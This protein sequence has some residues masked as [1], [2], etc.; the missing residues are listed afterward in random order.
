MSKKLINC[1]IITFDK[2][3]QGSKLLFTITK[4][5]ISIKLSIFVIK[6][7]CYYTRYISSW[8]QLHLLF[9]HLILSCKYF[10]KCIQQWLLVIEQVTS[11]L[12]QHLTKFTIIIHAYKCYS[13][14]PFYIPGFTLRWTVLLAI[15]K[16][17]MGFTLDGRFVGPDHIVEPILWLI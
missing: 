12:A 8:H 9:C 3:Y 2:N 15:T 17:F 6:R 5:I 11:I 13:T 14:C 4:C 16:T 1:Q 7:L 10:N